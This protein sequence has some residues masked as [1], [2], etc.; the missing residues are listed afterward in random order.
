MPE[1]NKKFT[2][3]DLF[4][5]LKTLTEDQLSQEVRTCGLDRAGAPIEMVWIVEEDQINPSGEG[6][7]PISFY[8]DPN[9]DAYTEEERKDILEEEK[10]VCTKGT[11]LL[12]EGDCY[13]KR[14]GRFI[15]SNIY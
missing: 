14:T 12:L 4:E 9:N 10:V 5:Q 1:E 3:K 8:T 7:E 15:E 6:M 11:I 2:Y 13:Y